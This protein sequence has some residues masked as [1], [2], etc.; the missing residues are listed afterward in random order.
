VT[1]CAKKFRAGDVVKVEVTMRDGSIKFFRNDALQG[2]G[3]GVQQGLVPY[4]S[5]WGTGGQATLLS[6]TS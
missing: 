6:I 5:L 3:L 2:E 4:N 1:H